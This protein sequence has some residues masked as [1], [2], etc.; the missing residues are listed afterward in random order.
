MSKNLRLLII[1]AHPDDCENSGGIALRFVRAGHTVKFV[2]V[3]NGCSGHQTNMGGTMAQ[4]RLKEAQKISEIFGVEYE[5]MDNNDAYLV[6]GIPERI[7]M[8]RV[9]R[10]FMPDIIITHRPNDYH[11]DH[12]AAAQLVQDCSYLVQVPNICPLTPVLRYQP[13]IFYGQDSFRK[14]TPFQADLVFDIS[15]LFEDKMRM[16]HQYVSQTYEW[17]P[18]VDGAGDIPDGEEERF[19]WLLNGGMGFADRNVKVANLYRDKLIEKYGERGK[20]A[21]RAEA[22]EISEYGGQLTEEQLAGYFPF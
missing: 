14:P 6:P 1:G 10:T 11:P 5:L 20:N 9:I 12:R 8:L 19:Q 4:T 3:T 13:A 16:Y 21:V 17:L 7:A 18:W 22:L 2:S 15:D